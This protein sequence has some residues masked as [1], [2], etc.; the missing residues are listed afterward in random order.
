MFRVTLDDRFLR[1][2]AQKWLH[3]FVSAVFV[4][5]ATS[6]ATTFS[7]AFSSRVDILR[8]YRRTRGAAMAGEGQ[9]A[10][11]V[12]LD[13]RFLRNCE[14]IESIRRAER[15]RPLQGITKLSVGRTHAARYNESPN[16]R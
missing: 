1:G 15:A 11:S 4:E 2:A 3:G 12:T 14:R 10:F 9:I 5:G 13:D 7:G 6:G 8:S 16:C